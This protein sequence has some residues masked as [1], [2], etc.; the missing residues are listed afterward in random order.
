MVLLLVERQNFA[1]L[2]A[3]R[4]PLER[5]SL[6]CTHVVQCT[7]RRGNVRL[8]GVLVDPKMEETWVFVVDKDQRTFVVLILAGVLNVRS[9][10]S[11]ADIGPL[12]TDAS[13][14]SLLEDLEVVLVLDPA[15]PDIGT[16]AVPLEESGID[17]GVD[18]MEVRLGFGKVD[19]IRRGH[20]HEDVGRLRACP[21][22]VTG[23]PKARSK[24]DNVCLLLM[25]P[26]GLGSPSI[27]GGRVDERCA[28]SRLRPVDEVI[29][30]PDD[31]GARAEAGGCVEVLS[32]ECIDHEIGRV[33]PEFAS[34]VARDNEMI[35]G[36]LG[37]DVAAQDGLT[38]VAGQA[39]ERMSIVAVGELKV[40]GFIF[41][42]EGSKEVAD[43]F[44][45]IR[46]T[47]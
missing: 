9:V 38:A 46:V 41:D 44:V 25:V 30:L 4:E 12:S 16:F 8:L 15:V 39:A 23:R 17:D 2:D 24:D 14:R 18:W 43:L 1:V 27:A 35:A 22:R 40:D 28:Q 47:L 13:R 33:Q 21:V 31:D 11:V 45:V 19:E 26:V 37:T 29:R 20:I 5:L 36:A 6:P 3:G 42:G 32:L 10:W 34:I 7:C